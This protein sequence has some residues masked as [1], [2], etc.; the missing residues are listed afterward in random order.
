MTRF[1]EVGRL[2][3]EAWPAPSTQDMGGRLLW[4]AGFAQVSG[5]HYRVKN[6]TAG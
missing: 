4:G 1:P 6:V 2:I 3:A 5:Y